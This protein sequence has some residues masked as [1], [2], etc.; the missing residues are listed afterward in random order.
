VMKKGALGI[1]MSLKK[2]KRFANEK[3]YVDL[4]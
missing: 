3:K 1:K 2:G 4:S